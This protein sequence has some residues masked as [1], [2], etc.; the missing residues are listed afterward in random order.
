[1]L[2]VAIVSVVIVLNDVMLSVAM[3]SVVILSFMLGD[4][5]SCDIM[6][7]VSS[8]IAFVSSVFMA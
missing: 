8:Y 5:R 3:P 2:S 7:H 4:V 1:M 6:Y